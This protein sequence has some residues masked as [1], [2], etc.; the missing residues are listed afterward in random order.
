MIPPINPSKETKKITAFITKTLSKTGFKNIIIALSGGLDSSLA[1]YLVKRAIPANNIFIV[2]LPYIS[3]TSDQDYRQITKNLKIPSKNIFVIN[4]NPIT[5]LVWQ[6][7]NPKTLSQINKIRLGNIMAR[8]RMV[9]LFD[10]AKKHKALVCGTENK[11]EHLLGYYTLHG[12]AAADLEPTK[13]LYKTQI[14]E[15][16]KYLKIPQKIITKTPSANLWQGQ[17]DENELGFSYL[18]ADPILYLLHDKKYSLSKIIKLGF[19]KKLVEKVTAQVEK[20]S[21]KPK[22]PYNIY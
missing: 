18:Q 21:F 4:I 17:T 10:L 15:L 3:L 11:S 8:T 7:T 16:A 1:A 19:P 12:D 5:D 6:K 9:I 2:H 20:N 22:L 13:H 14:I